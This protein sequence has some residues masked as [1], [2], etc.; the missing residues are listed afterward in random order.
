VVRDILTVIRRSG[1]VAVL[2]G[3]LAFAASVPASAACPNEPFRAGRSASLPDC[4]AYELVTP[5][6]LGR[7]ADV[8][9]A[10]KAGQDKA[11]VSSDGEHLALEAKGSFLEPGANLTGTNVVFART[12]GG[13]TMRSITAPGMAGQGL[14][15]RLLSPEFSHVALTSESALNTNTMFDAGSVGGPYS[16]LASVPPEGAAVTLVGANPGAPG[17]SPFSDVLVYTADRAFLPPGP[18][19]EQAERTEAP[20]AD[21]YEWKGGGSCEMS[22]SSCR[23]VNVDNEGKLLN[24]CGARLG[25]GSV[26]EGTLNAVSPDGSKFFFT[27]PEESGNPCKEEPQLYMRVRDKETVDVSAPQGVTVPP[28]QRGAVAYD[29]ASANGAKVFFTTTTALVPSAGAGFKLYEYDTQAVEGQRLKLIADEVTSPEEFINP[30]VIVSED[31]SAVY[32]DGTGILEAGGHPVSVTGIWRYDT[33]IRL[34][35]FVAK[36]SETSTAA[37]PDYT[38]PDGGFLVFYSGNILSPP[39]EIVG[40]NGLEPEPRGAGHEELY[41]YDA[42]NGNLTCVSCGEGFAPA[43]GRTFPHNSGNGL[44]TYPDS[45]RTPIS[46]SEDGRR[47]FFQTS[48]R[49]VPQDTSEETM[50]EEG[51]GLPG[52]A[53]DVY[54]WEQVG[55]EE[56][57]GVFCRTA[58]GC[59]HLIS[60][61]ETAGFQL[62]L[63]ASE[64]G[65]DLFFTSAAQLVP[66]ATP[67]F[68][69]IYDARVDGGFPVSA[70]APECTSCQGVGSPPPQFGTAASATFA[71]QGNPAAA[72][73]TPAAPPVK[74]KPKPKRRCKRG[75]RRNKHGRCV[76]AASRKAAGRR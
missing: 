16:T 70:P 45:V 71:G 3:V 6:H 55:S 34:R 76:R 56:A 49:L 5:E 39:V 46:M 22:G 58:V 27:S 8:S 66:Q 31:G 36:V 32:Y 47:V 41:R 61:G 73:G 48:A 37:Q 50:E 53:F 20:F 65:R 11:A 13:W 74:P 2:A 17:V 68:T 59:T 51:I 9:F 72:T 23:L 44:L 7:T 60:T 21:L 35:S 24:L 26:E 1:F 10:P 52:K 38:T 29:G 62:F 57:P 67:E 40:P 14:S 64:S 15:M 54:E 33:I 12:P 63:G 69:N 25:K 42:A 75:Y 19:R 30:F 18:E 28:D 43:K 4:R